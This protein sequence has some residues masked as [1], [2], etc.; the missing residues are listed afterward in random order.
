MGQWSSPQR[1]RNVTATSPA[2]YGPVSAVVST[3]TALVRVAVGSGRGLVAAWADALRWPGGRGA[4]LG[5]EPGG[6][7]RPDRDCLCP[8]GAAGAGAG[9]GAGRSAR[10]A[11]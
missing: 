4:G 9:A 3:A 6:G 7:A 2:C 1:H 5:G 10:A 11:G 8:R